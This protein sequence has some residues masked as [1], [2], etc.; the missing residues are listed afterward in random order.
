MRIVS[1]FIALG[2]MLAAPDANAQTL[3]E[4]L[5]LTL[6]NNPAI[7]AA[8][9]EL[10]LAEE[11]LL[12]ARAARSI[13]IST[14]VTTQLQSVSSNRL[15]GAL[16]GET[17]ISQ[18]SIEASI[19]IFTA[20]E[21]AAT[22]SQARYSLEAAE[23]ALAAQKQ[24]TLLSAI[25]AHL[26]VQF[27][28]E[29]VAIR[30]QNLIRLERQLNAARDRFEA[31]VV[32]RTDT[33]LAEARWRGAEAQLA[34]AQAE[35]EG[36]RARYLQIT[37][38]SAT[39]PALEG[40]PVGMPVSIDEGI[41]RLLEEN[42]N[43]QRYV[44]LEFMA[45]EAI[46]IAESRQRPRVELFGSASIQDGRWDNEFRDESAILGAR[47]SMPLYTGGRLQSAVRQAGMD[48]AQLRL[49]RDD[50]RNQLIAMFAEAW[51]QHRAATS[52]AIAAR[53]EVRANE[54]ALEGAEI[55]VSVGLRTTLDLLDQEQELLEAQL[56]LID[57]E[58]NV[59]LSASQILALLG[60][61][62]A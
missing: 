53:E 8:E 56:R 35:L 28:A 54:V 31:G 61:L 15:F 6:I 44:A 58:K 1:S 51:A 33:A 49:R 17:F 3:Q 30:E 43:L 14:G 34:G 25:N 39:Q 5:R 47:A 29:Q 59:Y 10:E 20:G 23:Y 32:T 16:A 7:A 52:S 22:I 36:A 38:E 24:E 11:T 55:E 26:G 42:P 13:E 19:P 27:A 21:I 62:G 46:R 48:R 41:D 18:A 2:V 37:G 4:T 60:A 50:A 45:G 12:V 40:L 9:I 57:A